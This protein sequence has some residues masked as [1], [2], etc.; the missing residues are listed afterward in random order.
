MKFKKK[1]G[2]FG[3]FEITKFSEQIPLKW[4]NSR[5]N[6]DSFWQG[7]SLHLFPI[8]LFSSTSEKKGRGV[9]RGE[10]TQNFCKIVT[11]SHWGSQPK[12]TTSPGHFRWIWV[13]TQ[14]LHFRT[15]IICTSEHKFLRTNPACHGFRNIWLVLTYNV[16]R[17]GE[18]EEYNFHTLSSPNLGTCQILTIFYRILKKWRYFVNFETAQLIS[19]KLHQNG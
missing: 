2:N 1:Y 4:W 19:K 5:Q 17:F 6:P 15:Q 16:W 10:E 12:Y 13:V 3:N 9:Y 14:N 18:E 7:S 11:I 8:F